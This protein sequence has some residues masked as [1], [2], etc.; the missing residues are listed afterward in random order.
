MFR[1]TKI[2]SQ[3]TVRGES[4][5]VPSIKF[6]DRRAPKTASKPSTPSPQPTQASAPSSNKN[7]N[8]TYVD[9]TQIP[10]RLQMRKEE[11]DLIS[12][13]GAF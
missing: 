5:R 11:M 3:L 12:S 8:Y 6:P 7:K 13:G 9:N 10:K 4:R 1:L 2:I